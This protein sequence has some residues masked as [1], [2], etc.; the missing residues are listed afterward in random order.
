MEGQSELIASD[1]ASGLCTVPR[2]TLTQN[3]GGAQPRY[4][5]RVGEE[6]ADE[7]CGER[8]SLSGGPAPALP[9]PCSDS[10]PGVGR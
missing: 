3:C 8:L 4:W 2:E 9:C 10:Q 1:T 6:G 5:T 7:S